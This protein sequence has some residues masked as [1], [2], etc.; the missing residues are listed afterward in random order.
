MSEEFGSERGAT[1]VIFG[2]TTF[3][4]FS[5]SIITGRLLDRFG[6]RL[7]LMIGAIAMF[8]GLMLTSRVESLGTAGPASRRVAEKQEAGEV[9]PS[10]HL[11][12]HQ[13]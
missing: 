8:T 13:G 11:Y 5:L 10:E 12:R 2:F 1:A 6:P 4:F 7:V 9:E 3:A